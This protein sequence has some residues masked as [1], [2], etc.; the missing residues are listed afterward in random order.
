MKEL[1]KS[2]AGVAFK[3]SKIKDLQSES[4]ASSSFSFL[5]AFVLVKVTL[6][7][8]SVP[9]AKITSLVSHNLYIRKM[10]RLR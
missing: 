7:M 9:T 1:V 4:I 10:E 3:F 5:T 2:T 8:S 6:I